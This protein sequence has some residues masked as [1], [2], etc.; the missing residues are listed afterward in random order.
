MRSTQIMKIMNSDPMSHNTNLSP[1]GDAKPFNG[2]I[3]PGGSVLHAI[4]GEEPGAFPVACNV[5]PWMKAWMISRNSP[6]FAVTK[7]D[8][9]F[10]IANLP[11]GV[12]LEFRVWQ[13]NLQLLESVKVDGTPVK[14]VKGK[15]KLKLEDKADVNINVE[16]AADLF[17]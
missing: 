6:Y 17:K 3:P 2:N 12:D 9:T 15:Y 7:D 13:E 11:A 16:I 8:G 10:E 4:G 14:W 5:H 1:K